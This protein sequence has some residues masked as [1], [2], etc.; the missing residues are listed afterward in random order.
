MFMTK[1]RLEG[2]AWDLLHLAYMLSMLCMTVHASS[3]DYYAPFCV[4]Y[5]MNRL[6][7]SKGFAWDLL[8]HLRPLLSSRPRLDPA[9]GPPGLICP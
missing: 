2:F 4:G 3:P 6:A 5:V 9:P 1:F 7:H 8:Q